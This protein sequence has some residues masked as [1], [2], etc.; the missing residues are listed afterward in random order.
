MDYTI[1][2]HPSGISNN[3]MKNMYPGSTFANWEIEEKI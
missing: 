1:P 2:T 3:K